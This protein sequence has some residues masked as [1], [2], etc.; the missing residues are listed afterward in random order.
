M[1]NKKFVVVD[2]AENKIIFRTK[3]KNE[4]IDY[5]KALKQPYRYSYSVMRE[6][7]KN[8]EYIL[9]FRFVYCPPT[10]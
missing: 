4:A 8:L 7:R 3:S 6:D 1:G 2:V 5:I 10:E 9:V